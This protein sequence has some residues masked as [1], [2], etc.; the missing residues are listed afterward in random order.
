MKGHILCVRTTRNI[1][2]ALKMWSFLSAMFGCSVTG[3]HGREADIYFRKHEAM[4]RPH[5]DG[6]S[7]SCHTDSGPL[8]LRWRWESIV[9][10]L[11]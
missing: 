7:P 10:D 2:L 4:V 9:R 1:T 5:V 8:N 6:T 3:G 11:N